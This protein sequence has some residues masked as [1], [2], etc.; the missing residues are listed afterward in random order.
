MFFLQDTPG[1]MHRLFVHLEFGYVFL[2]V[3]K[4]VFMKKII[5]EKGNLR[6]Y[7]S[8]VATLDY[9][10]GGGNVPTVIDSPPPTINAK[11]RNPDTGDDYPHGEE[12]TKAPP[13]PQRLTKTNHWGCMLMSLLAQNPT[14]C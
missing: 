14:A 13:E 8:K 3:C 1:Y 6:L 12:P 7:K 5:L 2:N 9:R 4:D 10:Y 11:E